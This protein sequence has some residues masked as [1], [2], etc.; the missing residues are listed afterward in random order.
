MSLAHAPAEATSAAPRTGPRQRLTYVEL[1]FIEKR[2][3]RWIRFGRV[4]EDRVLDRHTRFVG[5]AVGGV[6]AFVRWASNDYG[7]AISRLDILRAVGRGEAY[8]TVPGVLPGGELLLRLSGW[9]VVE[10]ALQA[11]DAVEA[12]GV[13]PVDAA[14]DHWRHIHN[15]LSV[16][17]TPRTYSLDRHAAW[18]RRREIEA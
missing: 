8:S 17:E 2:I 11:I 16:G 1:V 6:F 15:R 13:D 7:T 18:L 3:E 10:R 9:P 12:L 14:P 4:A 5:F